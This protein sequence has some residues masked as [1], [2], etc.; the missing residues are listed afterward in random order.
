MVRRVRPVAEDHELVFGGVTLRRE[1]PQQHAA[2]S[3]RGH[4]ATASE[5]VLRVRER[6]PVAVGV[7][8][9][10]LT[11][12]QV[13]GR[14]ARFDPHEA[15]TSVGFEQVRVVA[16]ESERQ[17]V[18]GVARL[19]VGTQDGPNSVH[20]RDAIAVLTDV[21]QQSS[22]VLATRVVGPRERRRGVVPGGSVTRGVGCAHA[23]PPPASPSQESF[24]S[25][26]SGHSARA[27]GSDVS[28]T[29]SS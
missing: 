21:F 10:V 12:G 18:V 19:G 14:R 27:D 2:R 16:V 20:H 5:D 1:R 15:V 7:F 11:G 6:H 8:W 28:V 25:G 13:K 3:V 26:L 24:E 17:P 9:A 29:L 22:L 4:G 23:A